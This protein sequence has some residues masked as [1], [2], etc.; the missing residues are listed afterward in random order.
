MNNTRMVQ[1][2]LKKDVL[3]KG[4]VFKRA[5]GYKPWLFTASID[6]CRFLKRPYSPIAI[7][8]YKMFK[9]HTNLNHSCPYEDYVAVQNFNLNLNN[10]PHALPTG[11]YLL[12]LDWIFSMK[13]QLTTK[14]YFEFVEDL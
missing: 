13:L 7:I 2:C 10:L 3:V 14:H 12:Q 9:K 6:G 11:D 1:I 8:V 4:Q 5:N